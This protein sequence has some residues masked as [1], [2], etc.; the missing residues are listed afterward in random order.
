MLP[1]HFPLTITVKSSRK[2]FTWK[3]ENSIYGCISLAVFKYQDYYLKMFL[4]CLITIY[5]WLVIQNRMFYVFG[6]GVKGRDCIGFYLFETIS[7][8]QANMRNM[9]TLVRQLF[10]YHK[11]KHTKQHKRSICYRYSLH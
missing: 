3:T 5:N 10:K 11:N 4:K 2:P 7:K 8:Y 1:I 6:V 9:C